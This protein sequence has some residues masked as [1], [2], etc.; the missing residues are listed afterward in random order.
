MED[1]LKDLAYFTGS[2]HWYCHP[3]FRHFCYTDGV[4]YV[5]EHGGAYWLIEKIFALQYMPE[6]KAAP[7][8]CWT[9]K[10]RADQSAILSCS[11]GNNGH[12][13]RERL[14]YTDFPRKEFKLYF[15]D[16]TLLLPSEY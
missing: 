3:L 2:E 4:Q 11:D 5:A 8:Q 16:R 15:C 1:K 7:F 6:L 12:L 10:V 14:I 9:L 13:Y